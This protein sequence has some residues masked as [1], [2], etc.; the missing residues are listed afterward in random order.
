[1]DIDYG[2]TLAVT[3]WTEGFISDKI[4]LDMPSSKIHKLTQEQVTEFHRCGVW[5]EP[6]TNALCMLDD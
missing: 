5:Y 4:Y 1:M 6:E 3:Q 2:K